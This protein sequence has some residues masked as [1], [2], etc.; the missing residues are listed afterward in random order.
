[1]RRLRRGLDGVDGYREG[2]A[3]GDD[4]VLDGVFD[5][6]LEAD[7]R[8]VEREVLGRDIFVDVKVVAV[9]YLHHIDIGVGEG[10]FLFESYFL[11]VLHRV[12]ECGSKLLEVV[13]GVVIVGADE[14]VEG[15][16]GVEKEMGAYL[17]L[18]GLIAGEDVFGLEVFVFEDKLLLAGDVVK[19]KRDKGGDERRRGVGYKGDGKGIGGV[20][21][22]VDD[23]FGV[24]REEREECS[25]GERACKAGGHEGGGF[26]SATN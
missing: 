18:K 21:C 26:E 3:L 24:E 17:L 11:G 22:A 6:E 14:A 16:E 10:K 19:E 5:K 20:A 4:V 9:A 7:G 23:C 8:H 25:D 15:V 1:M 2:M 12:A 13:V